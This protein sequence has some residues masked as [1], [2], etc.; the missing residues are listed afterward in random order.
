M[1]IN[2]HSNIVPAD[3]TSGDEQVVPGTLELARA[4]I[5]L[6]TDSGVRYLAQNKALCLAD[7][8]LYDLAIKRT[9]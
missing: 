9:G 6:C 8:K 1:V 7:R 3:G 2:H 4:I 5:K